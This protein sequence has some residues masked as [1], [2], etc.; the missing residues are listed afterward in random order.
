MGAL[1]PP[2]LQAAHIKRLLTEVR[3]SN[4]LLQSKVQGARGMR[5][6]GLIVVSLAVVQMLCGDA[7]GQPPRCKGGGWE[8]LYDRDPLGS[9][10]QSKK[11]IERGLDVLDITGAIVN[12]L[13]KTTIESQRAE[14]TAA[15]AK[16]AL[17]RFPTAQGA[18]VSDTTLLQSDVHGFA[19]LAPTEHVAHLLG[20]GGTPREAV[21]NA[22][23]TPA[24]GQ[25]TEL[26]AGQEVV[27]SRVVYFDRNGNVQLVSAELMRRG[28]SDGARQLLYEEF[29]HRQKRDQEFGERQRENEEAVRKAASEAERKQA[30]EDRQRLA[31]EREEEQKER[32][33]RDEKAER[34]RE[35]NNKEQHSKAEKDEWER[36]IGEAQ[37]RGATAKCAPDSDCGG[38]PG[39]PLCTQCAIGLPFRQALLDDRRTNRTVF[40]NE[41]YQPLVDQLISVRPFSQRYKDQ[42]TALDVLSGGNKYMLRTADQS[43]LFRKTPVAGASTWQPVLP[44]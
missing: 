7:M 44:R 14:K 33:E 24:V 15:V 2:D 19:V 3:A 6:I 43:V 10:A 31:K 41:K 36:L 16:A 9:T 28:Y 26:K 40:F 1:L 21:M 35:L 17:E 25:S 23:F 13:G 32:T 38:L 12:H 42:H 8:C 30:E 22:I 37:K 39:D 20:F 34:V 11:R 18:I 29:K 27:S 5:S 4:T